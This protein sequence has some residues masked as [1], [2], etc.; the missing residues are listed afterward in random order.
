MSRDRKQSK[1]HPAYHSSTREETTNALEKAIYPSVYCHKK[2]KK[3][4]KEKKTPIE[5]PSTNSSP[6]RSG[7]AEAEAQTCLARKMIFFPACP[8]LQTL[9]QR[10]VWEKFQSRS[11]LRRP[12]SASFLPDWLGKYV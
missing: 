1:G 8:N 9:Q 6:I 10:N 4:E 11:D 7:S 2:G 5:V 12:D 3:T